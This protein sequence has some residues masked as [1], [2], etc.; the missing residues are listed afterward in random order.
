MRGCYE[1]GCSIF[2]SDSSD[3]TRKHPL[4]WELT[5]MN[6]VLVGVNPGRA[7]ALIRDALA[8]RELG[9]FHQYALQQERSYG[10]QRKVDFILHGA[11]NY[12]FLQVYSVSWVEHGRAYFPDFVSRKYEQRINELA[13]IPARGHR[14]AIHFVV[15]R[16]DCNSVHPST[17][18]PAVAKALAIARTSGVEFTASRCVVTTTGIVL[19]EPIPFHPD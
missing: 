11:E 1:P 15:Q 5:D 19:G 17:I 2:L 7:V 12:V 14:A 18:D 4:T 9:Q 13:D 10:I 6:G 3:R 16:N 8:G